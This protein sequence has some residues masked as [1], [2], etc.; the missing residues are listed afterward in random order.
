M[1]E[2]FIYEGNEVRIFTN[3][4]NEPEFCAVDITRILGYQNGRDAIAKHCKP[5]GVTKRDTPTK[6]GNQLLTFIDEGNL[7]RLIL[8]SEKPEAEPF[9][10][11]VCDTVLPQIRKT[12]KFVSREP[13]KKEL[14]QMVI[15]SE[16][17]REIAESKV[18]ELTPKAEVY[19][20]I[21]NAD[22]LLTMNDTVKSIGTGR[23][24]MMAKLRKKGILRGNNTPYQKYIDIGYFDVKVNVIDGLNETRPQTFVTSKGLLWLSK[25]L[26]KECA[27]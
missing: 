8:K 3:E 5:K 16:N 2:L 19:D 13:S 23:N 25:F 7:Y 22:N 18:K 11:W 14:A 27:I 12:G 6:S 4:N 1:N 26:F 24:I 20:K 17:A 9:E 21:S 10:T 15:D